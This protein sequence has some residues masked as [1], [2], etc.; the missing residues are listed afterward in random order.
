MLL[1]YDLYTSTE[2]KLT[3]SPLLIG[4]DAAVDAVRRLYRVPAPFSPLL[5]G[6]DAAVEEDGGGLLR[7]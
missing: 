6:E 3:F 4:E 5:I 7:R 2:S 1:F